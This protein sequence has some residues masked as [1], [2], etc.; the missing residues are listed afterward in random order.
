MF[1]IAGSHD[2]WYQFEDGQYK[3]AHELKEGLKDFKAVK[4]LGIKMNTAKLL[5]TFI[6]NQP[7]GT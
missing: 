6:Q 5:S 4:S 2:C 7:K 3:Y 1:K